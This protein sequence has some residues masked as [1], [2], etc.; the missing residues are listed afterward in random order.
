MSIQVIVFDFDG[1]LVES[2]RL[3]FEAFFELFPK[4]NVH[5]RVIRRVFSE[6]P[7]A[8]RYVMLEQILRTLDQYRDDGPKRVQEL[9]GRYNEIVVSAAQTCPECPGAEA[10]LKDLV[11]DYCCYL[12]S[13]TPEEPLQE[14][15]AFRG[16][17]DY[18]QQI[19]GYPRKKPDTLCNIFEREGVTPQQVVVVGN[20]ESD[21]VSAE[22]SGCHFYDVN[23]KPLI[24]LRAFLNE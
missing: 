21:R 13:A 20:G 3:K 22:V 23:Q 6:C 24:A 4:D 17:T 2:D 7:E 19:F 5:D 9:A 14:I 15:V 8:S 18:F 11:P 10:V 12:S 16:W 1:T